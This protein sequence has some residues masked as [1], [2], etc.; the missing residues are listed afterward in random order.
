MENYNVGQCFVMVMSYFPTN[1]YNPLTKMTSGQAG[2]EILGIVKSNLF[3][4]CFQHVILR[5]DCSEITGSS[6]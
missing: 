5:K 2:W 6:K 4:A 3:E 1:S